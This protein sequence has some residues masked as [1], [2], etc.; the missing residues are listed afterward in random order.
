MM[1]WTMGEASSKAKNR[2]Y[3]AHL[4]RMF[5]KETGTTPSDYILSRISKKQFKYSKEVQISMLFG[6]LNSLSAFALVVFAISSNG[7]LSE[8][9][10]NAAV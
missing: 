5:K 3:P 4:S 8:L 7:L 6:N 2:K 9:A 10:T 1:I